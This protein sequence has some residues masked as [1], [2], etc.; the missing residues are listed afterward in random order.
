MG[1]TTLQVRM[2]RRPAGRVTPD[3]FEFVDRPCPEPGPGQVLVRN[4]WLSLDPY[5]RTRMDAVRTYVDPMQVGDLMPGGTV[6][7]VLA[8][9]ADTIPVGATVA[10]WLGWQTLGVADA[11]TL[12]V[13][14]TAAAPPQ[15]ALGVLGM[16]GVTA[17]YGLV[18]IGQA[19]AGE[20]VLVS[21][22]AGAVGG[23]VGQ[24]ARILGC[25]AVGIAGGARK[26]AYAVEELGYDACVDFRADD[27][28]GRLAQATP[29]GVDVLFE[30]VG[31]TVMDAGIARLND[32][33]RIAF[34][35]AVS[36]YEA[37]EPRGIRRV[38]DLLMRRATLHAFVI[39]DHRA[40][41]PTALAD[42]V[43]WHRDG[44]LRGREDVSDG[45][46]SAPAAFIRM[47]GGGNLGKQLV[48][49]A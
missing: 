15:A 43:A 32:F 48:R 9:R 25:R 24:I 27:F 18:R 28:A 45:L 36:E 39:A 49:I 10:G 26:C 34:C 31:G 37:A 38:R 33:A 23:V 22:A 2:R 40:Y 17:H 11:A 47:L 5:Q 13:L 21:A 12:R 3:D 46:R 14:D 19:R 42:L 44:R 20:T 29:S 35:G 41:Y 6:G 7:E 8:S 4:T 30:N 1:G 16:T